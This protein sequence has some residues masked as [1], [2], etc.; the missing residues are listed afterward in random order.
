MYVTSIL[1]SNLCIS[2]SRLLGVDEAEDSGGALLLRR[3][4]DGLLLGAHGF[5]V[6]LAQFL[7]LVGVVQLLV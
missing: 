6:P 1:L 4:E 2:V 7:L 3:L 5:E